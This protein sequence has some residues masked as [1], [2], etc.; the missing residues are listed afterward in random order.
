MCTATFWLVLYVSRVERRES[1]SIYIAACPP[2]SFHR[3]EIDLHRRLPASILSSI[4]AP[5]PFDRFL[6]LKPSIY[7]SIYTGSDLY[8]FI[9]TGSSTQVQIYTVLHDLV[10]GGS[11][12]R[13]LV[14]GGS[15][16]QQNCCDAG[17]LS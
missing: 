12:W 17:R 1:R 9:Y 8:R 4:S 7:T 11:G 15:R 13:Q 16:R 14:A 10:K 3:F 2:P 6:L 5:K